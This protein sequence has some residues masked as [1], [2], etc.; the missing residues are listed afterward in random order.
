M[1]SNQKQTQFK[2]LV[3]VLETEQSRKINNNIS[4]MPLQDADSSSNFERRG[5]LGISGSGKAIHIRG[6]NTK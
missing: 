4:F 2:Q 6:E 1:T 3:E 5:F